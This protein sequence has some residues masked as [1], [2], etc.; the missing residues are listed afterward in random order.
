MGHRV[1]AQQKTGNK[2]DSEA[3]MGIPLTAF[4][5]L[6][7]SWLHPGLKSQAPSVTLPT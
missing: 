4:S 7:S 2:E 5:Q 6:C 3:K 1:S